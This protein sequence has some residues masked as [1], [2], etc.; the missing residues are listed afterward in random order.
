MDLIG[1]TLT[2]PDCVDL[3]QGY[4]IFVV[5]LDSQSF[6]T[7]Q[8]MHLQRHEV[9]HAI[10]L[11]EANDAMTCWTEWGYVLPVM[12]HDSTNCASFPN[13]YTASYNEALYAVLRSGW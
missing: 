7:T 10:G 6:N 2:D 3:D 12:K 8:R 11:W 4:T 13:N 1:V 5:V 9:G